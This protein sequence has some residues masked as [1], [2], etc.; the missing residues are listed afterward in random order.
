MIVNLLQYLLK[1]LLVITSIYHVTQMKQSKLQK[2]S[3]VL[4]MI[5]AYLFWVQ[6]TK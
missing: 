2:I 4:S 1:L 5:V 6:N 3:F